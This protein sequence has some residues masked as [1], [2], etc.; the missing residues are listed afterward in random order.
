MGTPLHPCS[1]AAYTLDAGGPQWQEATVPVCHC[2][3]VQVCRHR[4]HFLGKY[5]REG[6]LPEAGKNGIIRA[7]EP[8][9]NNC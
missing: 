7:E 3:T 1:A 8:K 9:W 6:R 2:A 5:H 4:D